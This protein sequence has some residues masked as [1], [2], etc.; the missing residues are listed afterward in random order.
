MGPDR[1]V[2]QGQLV[3]EKS[4]GMKAYLEAAAERLR[5]MGAWVTVLESYKRGEQL[6]GATPLTYN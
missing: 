3:A 1:S 2:V 5:A 4:G 6:G